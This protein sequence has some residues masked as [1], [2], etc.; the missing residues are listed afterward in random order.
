MTPS[1]KASSMEQQKYSE[2]GM[3][4]V[5]GGALKPTFPAG[6]FNGPSTLEMVFPLGGMLAFLPSKRTSQ[7]CRAITGKVASCLSTVRAEE[8]LLGDRDSPQV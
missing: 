6:G 7:R 2:M 4:R 8:Y 5:S 3:G 1:P